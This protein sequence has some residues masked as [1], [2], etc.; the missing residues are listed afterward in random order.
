M[1]WVGWERRRVEMVGAWGRRERAE[2]GGKLVDLEKV[3]SSS[4]T[5]LVFVSGL[6]FF[7]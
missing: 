7:R 3:V 2:I 6:V 1:E 4:Q 5:R